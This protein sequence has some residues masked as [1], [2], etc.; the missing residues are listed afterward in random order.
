MTFI[1]FPCA[2][3][4]EKRE[5][6]DTSVISRPVKGLIGVTENILYCNDRP[7]CEAGAKNFTFFKGGV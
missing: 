6:K 1:T 2:I 3:C 7:G 5:D 4:G